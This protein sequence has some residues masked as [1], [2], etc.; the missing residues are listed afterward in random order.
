MD[1]LVAGRVCW[2]SQRLGL[3]G[4][5]AA[6]SPSAM[7]V[8][9]HTPMIHVTPGAPDAY[10]CASF[11]HSHKCVCRHANVQTDSVCMSRSQLHR[12]LGCCSL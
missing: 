4:W 1:C 10:L 6:A 8:S 11:A 9:S 2:M 5:G 3:R 7:L 12:K